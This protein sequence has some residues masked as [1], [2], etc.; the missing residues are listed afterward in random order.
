[1][2]QMGWWGEMGGPKQKGVVQYSTSHPLLYP[3]FRRVMRYQTNATDTTALSPYRQKALSGMLH[4]YVFA[5]FSR[6]MHHVPY[7]IIP[8]SLGE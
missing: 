5:G 6:F 7:F 3:S 1:M 2:S 8:V 4:G